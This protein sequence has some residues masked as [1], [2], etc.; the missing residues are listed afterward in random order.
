MPYWHIDTGFAALLMLLTA[1]DEGLGAC[2]FGIPPE[3]TASV[4][5]RVRRS[6]GVHARSA[7]LRS[8]TGRRTA[9]HRRSRRGR[10]PLDA[11]RAPGTLADGGRSGAGGKLTVGNG[12]RCRYAVARLA[13]AGDRDVTGRGC[14]VVIFKAVRDGR[15]YP[16]HG[17]TLKQWAEIPPRPVRLDQ[18]ITTKR[19]LALDKLLAEDSTFYGDLF[20]HVVQWNG[21]LYLEDGLH[22]ALRAALQ[23]RNQIHARVLVAAGLTSIGVTPCRSARWTCSTSTRCSPTRSAR[24]APSCAEVVDDRVRP[25]VAQLVRR[26]RGA[27]ARAGREFGKLG[28]LGMHL[29]GYGCA[30]ASAVAYG[31]A[32]MELEAGDSGRPLAGL[33]CRA[34][35]R[36][37]RSGATAARS[38]SSAGCPAMATGEA[39]GCFGLT[40][41]DH[42]S[43]PASMTTRARRDGDGWVLHGGKMWITNAPVADVAVDLGA[44]RRGGAPASSYR[45]TRPG[46]TAREIRHKL[47]LRASSH[48]R[49]RARRGPAARRRAAARGARAEGAAV[50]PHR[51]AATASSGARWAR[52]ATAC[53][54]RSSTPA[55]REQFGRPIA[56]FQLTQAKLADMARGAAEGLPAGAAP[57]PAGRRRPA[58]AGAGQRR[59]AEQRAGGDRDRPAV[60]HDPRRE[61]DQRRVPGACGTPTTWR[62]C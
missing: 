36:C 1:V 59:Q 3:R 30:G 21:G 16:E 24:S 43:D 51:G 39:I 25:Y 55:S 6:R 41:P 7:R 50:L 53:T 23:Q 32:C 57:G 18:L 54:R 11:G 15:P 4:P 60:P 13:P 9:G 8:A 34:R 40:E 12:P 35:W 26:R 22:R 20:P 52:P 5:G 56:G 33:A 28:L 31:L 46:V 48:R 27:G 45:W 47:S 19:E 62:A 17:L 42:G 44:R 37:T 29:T 14:A 58:A 49:D 2:F 10:R 38:R 61:R